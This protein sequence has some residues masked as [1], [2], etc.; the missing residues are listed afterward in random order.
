L[1]IAVLLAGAIGIAAGCGGEE[2]TPTPETVEGTLPSEPAAPPAEPGAPAAEGDVAAGKTVFVDNCGVCHTL[3]DAGSSGAVG[4]SL[5]GLAL[6][7]D[8]V[9]QQ[10]VNG[11]GGMPPFGS[12]LDEQQIND[13][14]AYV[15]QASA[16]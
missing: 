7:F 2:A 9:H 1:L 15:V 14:S 4:P 6:D 5:D 10:V 13:V 12:T 3:S 16:G 8:A 11:G